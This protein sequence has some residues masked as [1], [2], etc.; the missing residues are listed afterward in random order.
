[1]GGQYLPFLRYYAYTCTQT[2]A[3]SA[4]CV[5]LLPLDWFMPLETTLFNKGSLSVFLAVPLSYFG[6][7]CRTFPRHCHCLA[8]F[9]CLKPSV[10][11]P[12]KLKPEIFPPGSSQNQYIV[13]GGKKPLSCPGVFSVEHDLGPLWFVFHF[14]YKT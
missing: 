8:C 14:R 9:A 11:P 3:A 2:Y 13:Q 7:L 4:I 10:C 5:L 6:M 1:M 12:Q